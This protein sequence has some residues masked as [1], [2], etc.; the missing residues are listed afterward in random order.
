MQLPLGDSHWRDLRRRQKQ[1]RRQRS[2]QR[3]RQKNQDKKNQDKEKNKDQDMVKGK[4]YIAHH[5]VGPTG[6]ICVNTLKKDWTPDL[7]IRH[8][9]LVRKK[10]WR[11]FLD[12]KKFPPKFVRG[13]VSQHNCVFGKNEWSCFLRWSNACWLCPTLSLL[14]T[15]RLEN[16]C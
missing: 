13:R 7:G 4:F 9:L 2:R 15:R 1:R 5:Q 6:E 11:L 12:E 10:D 14:S 8:I 3:R 16:C